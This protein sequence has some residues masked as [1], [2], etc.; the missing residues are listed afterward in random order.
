M[1]YFEMWHERI[2]YF[3]TK[4]DRELLAPVIQ[5]C[6]AWNVLYLANEW[7]SYGRT[8]KKIIE[9]RY[10]ESISG[11][12]CKSHISIIGKRA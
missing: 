8:G 2:D 4:E 1:D 10:S 9:K 11:K 12:F 5:S 7:A 6:L 3:Q